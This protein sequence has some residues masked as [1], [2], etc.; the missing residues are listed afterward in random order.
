MIHSTKTT[1]VEV[2]NGDYW[3]GSVVQQLLLEYGIESFL[4][5]KLMGS[6]EPF[7]VIAGGANPVSIEVLSDDY[8]AAIKLIS[9]FDNASRDPDGLE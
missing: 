4:K 8:E 2:F 1:F 9:E 7:A 6:L 5:N 3:Q